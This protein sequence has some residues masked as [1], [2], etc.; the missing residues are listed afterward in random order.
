MSYLVISWVENWLLW[1]PMINMDFWSGD[2]TVAMLLLET[3]FVL[4]LE[5]HFEL[6]VKKNCSNRQKIG[7]LLKICPNIENNT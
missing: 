1:P 5:K 7:K 6:N 4:I 2:R 3:S